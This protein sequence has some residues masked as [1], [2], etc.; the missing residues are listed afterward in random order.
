MS[1]EEGFL[2]EIRAAPEDDCPRLVYAD[3]L[4]EHGQSERSE[5]IRV[6]CRLARLPDDHPDREGLQDRER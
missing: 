2:L 4:E 6:Q 5:F 3:W 1:P